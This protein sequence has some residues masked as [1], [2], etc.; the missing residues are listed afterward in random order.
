[1]EAVAPDSLAGLIISRNALVARAAPD[2]VLPY[3]Y[4]TL[5]RKLK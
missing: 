5:L 4:P 2:P 1:L 3:R